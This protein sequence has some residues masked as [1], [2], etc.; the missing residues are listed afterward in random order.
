MQKRNLPRRLR[1]QP[2]NLPKLPNLPSQ[3]PNPLH[4]ILHRTTPSRPTIAARHGHNAIVDIDAHKA[5]VA[6]RFAVD[7][8]R[9]EGVVPAILRSFAGQAFEYHAA[10]HGSDVGG[11]PGAVM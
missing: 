1:P 4:K 8:I 9:V 6:W 7:V 11:A 5:L 10:A 2:T 3:T